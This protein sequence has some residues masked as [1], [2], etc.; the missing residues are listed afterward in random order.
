MNAG[1]KVNIR[2]DEGGRMTDQ[3]DDPD[4]NR[5]R[6]FQGE[7]PDGMPDSE[8]RNLVATAAKMAFAAEL[9]L[10]REMPNADRAQ[11]VTALTAAAMR[12]A[13]SVLVPPPC[14]SLLTREPHHFDGRPPVGSP[15]SVCSQPASAEIHAPDH[16]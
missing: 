15:V 11:I 16:T 12:H 14:S 10:R 7:P 8:W 1:E 3:M 9:K 5:L 2:T 13:V 4:P 6:R